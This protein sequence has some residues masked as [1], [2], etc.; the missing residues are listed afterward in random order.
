MRGYFAIGAER[1]SKPLNLGNLIRSAHAFGASF[2]FTVDAHHKIAASVSDTSHTPEHVPYFPWADAGQMHL[3]D[4]C[5]LVGIELIDGAIDLPA[6][7]HP[8]RAAYI[9][10]PERGE[11]SQDMLR[12]CDHVIA[13]PTRFSIN[14]AVAGAIVMYDR[15]RTLGWFPPR[16]LVPGGQSAGRPVPASHGAGNGP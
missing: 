1:I 15:V 11:L 14:M 8:P 9:L 16:P 5:L 3:P 10:G 4:G 7:H 6:F 13:I 12:R 2:V